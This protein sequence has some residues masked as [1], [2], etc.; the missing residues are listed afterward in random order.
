MTVVL[1][2]PFTA[3]QL[4]VPVQ[5]G[6]WLEEEEL[7]QL[8]VGV[9]RDLLEP[10]KQNGQETLLP[11]AGPSTLASFRSNTRNCCRNNRISK[12]LSAVFQR[13][14]NTSTSNSM[15]T[16]TLYQTIPIAP[17]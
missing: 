5:D 10:N 9:P 14:V 2:G 17:C 15:T 8:R 6:L 11:A 7:A 13:T 12:S 3:H 4:T 16:A 1:E